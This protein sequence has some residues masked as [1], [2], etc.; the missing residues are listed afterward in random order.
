M[1]EVPVEVSFEYP[2]VKD[3]VVDE[4]SAWIGDR[5]VV[6]I[7]KNKEKAKEEYAQAIKEGKEAIYAERE[8]R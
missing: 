6:A 5:N 1:S 4:F 8:T 3:Q 7:I 2:L